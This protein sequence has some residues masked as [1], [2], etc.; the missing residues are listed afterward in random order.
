MTRG[1]AAIGARSEH[2]LGHLPGSHPGRLTN[3]SLEAQ[4]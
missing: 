3:A 2:A 4:Q 1:L